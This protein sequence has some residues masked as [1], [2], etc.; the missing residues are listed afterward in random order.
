MPV[1]ADGFRVNNRLACRRRSWRAS[2]HAHDGVLEYTFAGTGPVAVEARRGLP[3]TW[4]RHRLT[5]RGTTHYPVPSRVR[6]SLL[7]PT[8]DRLEAAPDLSP[9]VRYIHFVIMDSW[10]VA[11]LGEGSV[12]KSAL[13]Q[14]VR[15]S[16][17]AP[18]Y[19]ARADFPYAARHGVIRRYVALPHVSVCPSHEFLRPVVSFLQRCVGRGSLRRLRV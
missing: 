2:G 14:Q 7:F 6:R 12:G 11:M 18:R 4:I 17:V 10:A 15:V 3:G 19:L 1:I 5:G 16:P 9:S 13:V 8:H